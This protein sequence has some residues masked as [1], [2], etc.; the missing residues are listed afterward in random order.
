MELNL[1]LESN[2]ESIQEEL[3]WESEPKEPKEPNWDP[4]QEELYW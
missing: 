2:G 4:I 3:N 1:K